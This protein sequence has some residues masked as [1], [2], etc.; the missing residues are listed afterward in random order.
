MKSIYKILF[1]LFLGTSMLSCSDYLDIVPDNTLE[2]ENI[3]EKKESAY[4]ALAR[5]YN[6]MPED[7]NTHN[8]TW[9]LGDEFVGRLDL[10]NNSGDLKGIRI[11][12][13]LQS[14]SDPRLGFWSGTGGAKHLYK[15]IRQADVFIT[16]IDRVK[17]M[18][19]TEVKNWKAQAK[20]LKAYY[21]FLLVQKYGPIVIP[22]KLV[23]ADS[24]PADLFLPRKKIDY[25][26]EYILNLV[27]EAIPDLEVR[28]GTNDLG[29]VD[30][31]IARA[32][33]ARILFFRASPFFNGNKEYFGDFFDSDGQP[34]FPLEYKKEKWEDALKAVNAAIDSSAM[35]GIKMYEY[36][37]EPYLY[38]RDDMAANGENLK[39]I[40]D[41]RMII[42]DPW[43]QELIWGYSNIDYYGQ[44]DLASSTNMRLPS[45]YEGV[46][47]TAEFSWQW[48][49]ATYQV[50]ERYYTENGLPI[51]EDL[52][53]PYS[54]MYDV[55]S[56]PGANEP[57]YER[58]RGI[59][60][61]GVQTIKFNLN[62]EPRFYANLG[63]TGGYWRAHT[64]RI[65]SM[66]FAGSDGGYNSSQHT[67]DFY[68]GGIALQK[69]VHPENMSGAWQ[70]TIKYPF[71]IIRL[72]DLYLM[73]AE[74]LNEI[75]DAPD[76]E[77]WDAI[78]VVRKRAGIPL[79]ENVWGD[80]KLAKTVNKHKTKE[81]MRDIILRERGI[82]LAFEGSRYWD[83]IRHK[84]ATSEFSI[85]VS[86]W[87]YQGT[88][89]K[90]FFVL[91]VLQAR[92]FSI[93]DCL[94]PISLDETN[95]N[96]NLIQNPGW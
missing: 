6:F 90:D 33:K 44:G 23:T 66:F 30:Q 64:V 37:K 43:N 83:M 14:M 68:P 11:M 2:L 84:K 5:V 51:D 22:D 72:A 96:G 9:I 8:S 95:T 77:V 15:G 93:T 24:E 79:I 7:D 39:K 40:Y 3:F 53:Y 28:A 75:K 67:T 82:E 18:T 86:G 49:G 74:I 80:A 61:P 52:T 85:P 59:M 21:M 81:G 47:N 34:F 91:T 38:D 45:G 26:F 50:A 29:Q 25:C 57:D 36:Q 32:I 63:V 88:N 12:R 46:T 16:N 20:F 87:N 71:P 48:M 13:G 19:E 55:V 94:W 60:Q 27:E 70:R 41:L 56:T 42:C 62:R 89:A 10:N 69:F 92:K 76:K 35:F 1:S 65:N 4:D 54:S 78:N 73:K 17:D 31:I 58:L